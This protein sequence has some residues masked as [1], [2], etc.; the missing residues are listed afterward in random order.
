MLI[1]ILYQRTGRPG[2]PGQVD[3]RENG[4]QTHQTVDYY[5]YYDRNNRVEASTVITV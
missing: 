3:L 2:H 4:Y 5:Y 1:Y